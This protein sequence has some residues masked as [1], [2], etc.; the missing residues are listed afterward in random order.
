MSRNDFTGRYNTTYV[1]VCGLTGPYGVGDVT[2]CVDA[3]QH[4]HPD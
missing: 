2:L 3:S 1:R 4:T